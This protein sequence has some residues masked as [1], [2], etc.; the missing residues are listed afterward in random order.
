MKCT[1]KNSIEEL[2][3]GLLIYSI[4]YENVILDGVPTNKRRQIDLKDGM[5][6]NVP[7]DTLVYASGW[8]AHT[9]RGVINDTQVGLSYSCFSKISFKRVSVDP[10]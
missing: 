8:C 3:C 5:R 10:P 9:P 6:V 7:G 1:G 2:N 4:G